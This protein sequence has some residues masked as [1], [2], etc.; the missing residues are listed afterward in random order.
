MKAFFKTFWK[1]ISDPSYYKELFLTDFSFSL[2]YLFFLLFLISLIGGIIFSA[3]V[4]M[5]LPKL[6]GFIAQAKSTIR[7]F[8]PSELIITVEDGKVKTNVKEPY[9]IEFPEEFGATE[10]H[11]ITIDTRA[12]FEDIER[13]DTT[14]LITDDTVFYADDPGYK[15]VPISKGMNIVFNKNVYDQFIERVLPYLDYL[16]MAVYVLII[17]SLVIWPFL[18]AGLALAGRMIY[19]LFTSVV[20]WVVI[21]IMKKDLTYQKIYQLSIHAL[22]L[23]II[24]STILGF[25]GVYIPLVYTGLLIIYMLIVVVK[26]EKTPPMEQ[27]LTQEQ[28]T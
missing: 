24:F 25:F 1:S 11:F 21:K 3:R 9:F 27:V 5:Y 26:F 7:V 15:T 6:P 12:R 16:S 28:K 22:S 20:L 19:L 8:Y 14:V 17:T 18:G 2:K 13:Y 23:P 10:A 4:V